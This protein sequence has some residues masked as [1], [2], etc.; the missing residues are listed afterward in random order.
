M[1]ATAQQRIEFGFDNS[2]AR[3]PDRFFVRQAPTAMPAPRLI[4]LNTPLATELGLDADALSAEGASDIFAGNRVPDDAAPLAMAY[5]GH[6]FGGFSPQ[7]GD[8]RAILLGELIASDGSRRDVQLKGAGR[9]PFSRGG[10]GRAVLGPVL[11]EFI[12]SEAMYHLGIPTTRALAA[13]FT[14]ERIMR[15]RQ[16]PGAIL[17]RV[18]RS[19]VRVGT[20]EYFFAR[21]DNEAVRV[22]ADYIIDRHYPEA[23]GDDNCYLALF[24]AVV[25]RHA[26]LVAQW[27]HVGFI[28]GV[29][30]TDNTQIAGETIDY[31]PCAFMDEYHPSTVFSSIDRMGRYAYANQPQIAQWN[32]ACFARTLLPLIDDDAQRAIEQAQGALDSYPERFRT[33]WLDGMRAKLG[34]SALPAV[35]DDEDRQLGQDLLELMA[36]H[37]ADFTLTFRS[38][39]ALSATAELDPA[40]S[41]DAFRTL[42][43]EPDSVDEWLARWRERLA[44]QAQDDGARQAGMRAVNPAFIPRNHLVENAIQAA[45][46]DDF[47]PFEALLRVL[48]HPFEDNDSMRHLMMPPLSDEKVTQTFCG[49]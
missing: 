35:S 14:G 46:E 39:C 6:Q 23:R 5:A 4:R 38:L 43:Q 22:L 17:T 44:A 42:F 19:H 12:V 10:D 16:F 20:F 26:S 33:A 27:M 2:Y 49:T 29:M 40:G 8:G 1:A 32:L 9:T 30:N 41:E 24:N 11:R 18:A 21:E 25:A 31:G 47:R 34:L 3:L 36:A 45:L 48:E 28:H 7:L 13:A 15:E 37:K